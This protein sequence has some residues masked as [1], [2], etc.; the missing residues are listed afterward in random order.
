M[1]NWN[2]DQEC[3]RHVEGM[4]DERDNRK[5]PKKTNTVWE[6]WLL[7]DWCLMETEERRI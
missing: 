7:D 3:T 4:R 6:V 5:S 2:T 1:P